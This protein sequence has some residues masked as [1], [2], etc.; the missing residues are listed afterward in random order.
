[1]ADHPLR[2]A[3]RRRLGGPLPHQ[4]PDGP[5][6]PPPA[7]QTPL[8][9]TNLRWWSVWGISQ[10]FPWLSP[11]GGQV[12]H[13]LLTRPPLGTPPQREVSP[14]RLACVRH[15][16]SVHPE[17][18]S[19]PSYKIRSRLNEIGGCYPYFNDPGSK[20]PK[21]T[22]TLE[23]VT[24]LFGFYSL[25]RFLKTPLFNVAEINNSIPSTPVQLRKR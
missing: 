20:T 21:F 15:A 23:Y 8:S 9:S 4:L 25:F 24:S 14:A 2:P 17:P 12:T 6:A 18:G 16:A 19:N 7:G 3:T 10:G 5:R 22:S 13:V 11:S 1:M